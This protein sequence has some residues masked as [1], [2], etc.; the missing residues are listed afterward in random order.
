MGEIVMLRRGGSGRPR[1]DTAAHH[2]GPRREKTV[3]MELVT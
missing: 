1:C 2:T 3:G